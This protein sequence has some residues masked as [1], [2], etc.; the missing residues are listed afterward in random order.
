MEVQDDRKDSIIGKLK[1]SKLIVKLSGIK[2]I[3][4]VV[5]IIIIAVALIIYSNVVS[6][7]KTKSATSSASI[8]TEEELR[9]SSVL[10]SIDGAGDVRVMISRSAERVVG[11]VVIAEGAKDISVRL[12]LIDATATALGIDKSL[13]NVYSKSS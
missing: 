5:A 13:V 2:N 6:K 8:M 4:I 1:K 3:Q 12:R 10:G 11:V 9:L 7:T